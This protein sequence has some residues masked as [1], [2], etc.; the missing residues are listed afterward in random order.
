MLEIDLILRFCIT[1][2]YFTF[3]TCLHCH[4]VI[5]HN[6]KPLTVQHY[7]VW[8]LDISPAKLKH[9]TCLRKQYNKW[10]TL[11]SNKI[12]YKMYLLVALFNESRVHGNSAL[13][14]VRGLL[15]DWGSLPTKCFKWFVREYINITQHYNS[16]FTVQPWLTILAFL[17]SSTAICMCIY[18]GNQTC[19]HCDHAPT[20]WWRWAAC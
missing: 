10:R 12:C 3:A 1:F 7:F 14:N 18:S 17:C 11:Y 19:Y 13:Q 4:S 5:A 6:V 15:K 16:V 2:A 20:M 8:V 9:N